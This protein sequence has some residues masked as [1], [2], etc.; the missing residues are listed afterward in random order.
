MVHSQ[1][2][3]KSILVKILFQTT[4]GKVVSA[5]FFIW[6]QLCRIVIDLERSAS[7]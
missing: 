4:N 6:K 5:A 3:Q 1:R 7:G 2:F